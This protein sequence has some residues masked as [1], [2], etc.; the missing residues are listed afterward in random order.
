M[1]RSPIFALVFTLALPAASAPAETY[2]IDPVHSTISFKIRHLMAKTSGT[3]DDFRGTLVL[4]PDDLS[5]VEVSVSIDCDSVNT[6]NE[7][8]DQH[9]RSPEFFDSESFPQLKFAS[10]SYIP[11][12]DGTG[13][14]H[15][16]LTIRGVTRPVQLEVEVLGFGPDPWGG[17]RA[18]FSGTTR[19]N[20]K[21]FGIVWNRA[22]D[23][24]GWVLGDEVT[25]SIDL[26]AIRRPADPRS[27]GR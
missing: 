15:G 27:S 6:K 9:L 19:I 23:H 2:E 20:R 11:R 5:T 4:D 8:R 14:L 25:I 21:E 13:V 7:D 16:H 3:F 17:Y 1:R 10:T 24:G 12:E 22:M 18:G 26:E